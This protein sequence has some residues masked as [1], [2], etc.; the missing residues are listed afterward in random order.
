M[1]NNNNTGITLTNLQGNTIFHDV[2][3]SYNKALKTIYCLYEIN[4]NVS[5]EIVQTDK[6]TSPPGKP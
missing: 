6:N 3:L 5:K 2:M 4:S 1:S